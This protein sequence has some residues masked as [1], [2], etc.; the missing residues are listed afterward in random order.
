MPNYGTRVTVNFNRADEAGWSESYFTSLSG[1][2]TVAVAFA[3]IIAARR[4]LLSSQCWV[5]SIRYS[6]PPPVRASVLSISTNPQIV[7]TTNTSSPNGSQPDTGQVGVLIS[8]LANIGGGNIRGESRI[9]RG[10]ADNSVAWSSPINRMAPFGMTTQLN[11]FSNALTTT[12]SWGWAYRSP[13]GVAGAK[14]VPVIAIA[15]ALPGQVVVTMGSQPFAFPGDGSLILSGFRGLAAIVNGTYGTAQWAIPSSP[16]NTII[17]KRDAS[18]TQTDAYSGTG[19]WIRAANYTFT[20][21][22]LAPTAAATLIRTRNIGNPFGRTRGRR[23]AR[24]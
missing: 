8:L 17:L 14:S 2:P 20:P 16:V 11:A 12:G 6:A 7:T 19:G 4:Q 22:L 1:L 5:Y 3:P 24:R 13:G 10:L 15:A 18:T 21:Y 23:S 9:L